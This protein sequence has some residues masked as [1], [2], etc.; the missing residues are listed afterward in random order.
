LINNENILKPLKIWKYDT[1]PIEDS[2]SYILNAE[3]IY[4]FDLCSYYFD[5]STNEYIYTTIKRHKHICKNEYPNQINVVYDT[6]EFG[7]SGQI[8][9]GSHNFLGSNIVIKMN[10]EV[11][12]NIGDVSE[13]NVAYFP[14]Y[15]GEYNA[16]LELILSDTTIV[17]D[18]ALF[19]V[20][21]DL[22]PVPPPDDVFGLP[23]VYMYAMF[24][25]FITLGFL[26]LPLV[27]NMKSK[28]D[29]SGVVYAI[30][31]G[32]GLGVSTLAGFFPLWLPLMITILTVTVLV[33]EYKKG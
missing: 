33:I 24:G 26:L 9:Y 28:G 32:I 25:A 22:P 4:Y 30:F 1:V 29:V 13:F 5:D 20:S 14:Q 10:G 11:A 7:K 31:G 8:V 17:L 12:F 18:S 15:S 6:I 21:S 23:A 2:F 27:I 3:G 16:T 19:S